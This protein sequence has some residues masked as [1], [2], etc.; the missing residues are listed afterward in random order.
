MLM[1]MAGFTLAVSSVFLSGCDTVNDYRP[2]TRDNGHEY[3]MQWPVVA[4]GVVEDLRVTEK[5][6]TVHSV[7]AATSDVALGTVGYA[8]TIGAA[9]GMSGLQSGL[10]IGGLG[11]VF[12]F[13]SRV[14]APKV[15]F[16]V[17][18]SPEGD[19]VNVPIQPELLER[20]ETNKCIRLG[21]TVRVVQKGNSLEMFNANPDL[22]R[23][24]DFGPSCDELRAKFAKTAALSQ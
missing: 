13:I 3:I 24:S 2:H 22:L 23:L 16:M 20:V 14:N 18:R 8:S 11:A 4:T 7:A 1:R 19:L 12:D 9:S 10:A 5:N 15:E 17:R 21:D 6:G